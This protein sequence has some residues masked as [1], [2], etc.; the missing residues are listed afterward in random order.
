MIFFIISVLTLPIMF[1]LT[2]ITIK[3]KRKE[4]IMAKENSSSTF[5][6]RVAILHSSF[7]QEKFI[8][9]LYPHFLLIRSFLFSLLLLVGAAVPLLQVIYIV[10]AN[11]GIIA[12]LL[13]FKPLQVKAQ[14]I[15]TV[16]YEFFFLSVCIA[17]LILQICIQANPDDH[18]EG[19][20]NLFGIVILTLS[21]LM[22]AFNLVSFCFELV[23]LRN[24]Y[25]KKKKN[26]IVPFPLFENPL[27]PVKQTAQANGMSSPTSVTHLS[28]VE[29]E[30]LEPHQ[31]AKRRLELRNSNNFPSM[32]TQHNLLSPNYK[33]LGS[34]D[35][36]RNQ[37][38]DGEAGYEMETRL[39]RVDSSDQNTQNFD[40]FEESIKQVSPNKHSRRQNF[41]MLTESNRR[42]REETL[43]QIIERKNRRETKKTTLATSLKLD[44]ITKRDSDSQRFD[45]K[46]S[47][48]LTLEKEEERVRKRLGAKTFELEDE[49]LIDV[50]HRPQTLINVK[51]GDLSEK[52]ER[53]LERTKRKD[54]HFIITN[55]EDGKLRNNYIKSSYIK[56]TDLVST[57]SE[58]INRRE[59]IR[60]AK[61]QIASSQMERSPPKIDG[62]DEV[63]SLNNSHEKERPH[64]SP[65]QFRG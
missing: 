32:E 63:L 48:N 3:K 19:I 29:R 16:I 52:K 7:K 5:L 56:G 54:P 64:S 46:K 43:K 28:S 62:F 15:L 38:N 51:T 49:V 25:F 65:K 10:L 8:Y 42:N 59:E 36:N 11:V 30:Y 57:I 27:A 33:S 20:K 40:T 35:T 39:K 6:D 53:I 21:T 9:F 23:D 31:I 58:K 4:E 44:L 37:M 13:Y 41:E 60:H 45:E 12:Y 18:N 47:R 61:S 17:V 34:F 50:R 2:H 24:K 22:F 26:K 1:V 14:Q 55:L